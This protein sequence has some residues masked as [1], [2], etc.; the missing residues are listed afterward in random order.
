[1]PKTPAADTSNSTEILR[2]QAMWCGRR[3]SAL[4]RPESYSMIAND[5]VRD[6]PI[7]IRMNIDV[8]NDECR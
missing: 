1:M 2:S 5:G 3:P 8:D 7:N 4:G 6:V